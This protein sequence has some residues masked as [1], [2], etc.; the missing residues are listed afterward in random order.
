M[1]E[2]AIMVLRDGT[3]VHQAALGRQGIEADTPLQMDTIFR[4]AAQG[5]RL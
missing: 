4:I 5:N 2:M 1:A 3:P